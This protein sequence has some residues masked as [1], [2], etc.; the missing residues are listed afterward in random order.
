MAIDRPALEV[1]ADR[2]G[3][4]RMGMEAEPST[5]FPAR[6]IRDEGLIHESVDV[7]GNG[8]EAGV[9]H[10]VLPPDQIQNDESDGHD[11]DETDQVVR[12]YWVH[13]WIAFLVIRSTGI[14]ASTLQY[15]LIRHGPPAGQGCP[16]WP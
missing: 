13:I 16:P 3:P 2:E 12:I 15:P 7:V 10:S 6:P 14:P 5:R 9:G 11:Q 4:S 8:G 1:D